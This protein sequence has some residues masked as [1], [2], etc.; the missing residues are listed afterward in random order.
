MV[1][2]NR[3]S[4]NL[5][6]QALE[7]KIFA[8]AFNLIPELGPISLK[9]LFDYFG[10][11]QSAW[12]ADPFEY[13]NVGLRA[14][15]IS[16]IIA[17][18]NKINPEQAFAELTRRQIEV[19]LINE[20]E[21]PNLLREISASPAILYTRGNKKALNQLS[22]GVVGTRKMSAYGQQACEEVVSQLVQAN[23]GIVSGLA[24]GIDAIALNACVTQ[25][26]IPVAVL[27]S[28]LDNTSISPRSNFNLAQKIISMGCLVSEFPL[29]TQVQKQNF[30]IRNRIIAGLS[31]GTLVIEADIQ[32]GA[33]ITANFA[34][35]QNRE[36]FAIPGSI[37]SP[38]SRGT[39]ALIKHG[40]KIVT[41]ANDIIEELNLTPALAYESVSMEVSMEEEIILNSLTREP[42]HIDDLIKSVKLNPGAVNA[43]L[44][45]LEMKGRIKNLG[46]AKYAKIR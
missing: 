17:R 15:T 33:L 5:P 32:S 25:E 31:V 11:L 4:V 29:G 22:I 13:T 46:G 42:I 14:K 36:V 10:T 6:A 28:D 24:F 9:K 41:S 18:K 35:E 2:K 8:H 1:A 21:Y 44:T 37:F 12:Y 40:A 20:P 16:Q 30:P 43:S 45:L 3:Q 38:V 39:N 7:N 19:T 23:V 34:L 27:A 26:G